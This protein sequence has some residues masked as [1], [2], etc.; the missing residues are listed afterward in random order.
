MADRSRAVRTRPAGG[1]GQRGARSHRGVPR[2]PDPAGRLRALGRSYRPCGRPDGAPHPVRVPRHAELAAVGSLSVH[3]DPGGRGAVLCGRPGRGGLGADRGAVPRRDSLLA[4]L[5]GPDPAG[6]RPAGTPGACGTRGGTEAVSLLQVRGLSKRFGGVLALWRCDLDVQ[7]G[8]VHALIGPNGAGK[9]TLVN[10]VSGLLAPT[11]GRIVF[12]GVDITGLPPHERAL[13]GIARTFQVTNLFPQD[14]VLGNLSLVVQARTGSSFRFWRPVAQETFLEQEARSYAR[15]VDLHGRLEVPVRALSHGEQRQLEVGL[16]L[17]AEPRLVVLDEPT[18]GMGQEESRA[19][20]ELIQRL[21]GE[22]AILL[23]EHDMDVVFQVADRIT[24]LVDGRVVASGP[25]EVVREDPEVHRAYLGHALEEARAPRASSRPRAQA[26]ASGP[27]LLE[28]QGLEASYGTSQVLFGVDLR[29]PSGHVV[30]LLGRNG[31]GKTTTVRA[32]A[33]LLRPKAGRVRFA[34]GE[35]QGQPPEV[36][37][38]LGVALVPE[39]RQIFPNLTVRENL[40]AFARGNRAAGSPWT[41]DRVLELF[42]RLGA[43]LNQLGSRL[44]GGEQQMLA[45]GRALMTNPRLLVLD[46]ATEGL[47]PLVREEIWRALQRLNAEGLSVLLID[48]YVE[49][50]TEFAHYH[51]ILE[52]G[53]VVWEGTSEALR[54]DRELWRRYLSV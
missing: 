45:I 39:G 3:G 21:R 26:N 38:S 53:R 34:G 2:V 42:P 1:A 30:T 23:V 50:L 51:Y 15:R 17:A 20:V 7:P 29:V 14:T 9:T 40:V 48:K 22:V 8:E 33:G 41:L 11:E 12:R 52:R 47:A 46:E 32:L 16:A 36:V 6:G 37:A 27:A 44:S 10:L 13:L 5:R 43:R 19:V 54:E 35:I 24:V 49:R 31:M 28:V 18:S 4:A 25:P